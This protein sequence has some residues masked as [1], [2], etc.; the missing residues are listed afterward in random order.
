MY[1][2]R[3]LIIV[4]FFRILNL[5]FLVV[6]LLAFMGMSPWFVISHGGF[7][8]VAGGEAFLLAESTRNQFVLVLFDIYLLFNKMFWCI[9]YRNI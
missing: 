7:W 9:N 6:R 3:D 1:D 2:S 5:L 8:R 4:F